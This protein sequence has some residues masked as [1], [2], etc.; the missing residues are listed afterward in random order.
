MQQVLYKVDFVD[1]EHL[2]LFRVNVCYNLL[3]QVVD[4]YLQRENGTDDMVRR[5][6]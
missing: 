4:D 1:G 6:L 3:R 5:D 2:Q